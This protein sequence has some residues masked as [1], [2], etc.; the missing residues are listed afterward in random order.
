MFCITNDVNFNCILG[1]DSDDECDDD[2]FLYNLA[3]DAAAWLSYCRIAG[4]DARK[5]HYRQ[6]CRIRHFPFSRN[7]HMFMMEAMGENSKMCFQEFS[8]YPAMLR[9]F[10]HVLRDEHGLRINQHVN[11]YEQVGMFLCILAHGKGYRQV[12]TIF[13]HSLET[14]CHYV[15]EVLRAIVAL[16]TRLIRLSENYN[17]G[18]EPHRLDLS[19]HPLFEDCIGAI[20]GTHVKAM[21]PRY[22]RV[23]FIGRKGVPTQNVLAACDFNLFFT[24]VLAGYSGNTHDACMLARA[25]H[26]SKIHFPLPALGKYYL[27]DSGFAHRPRYMAPYKGSDILYHFQQFRD[28]R[29][30]SHRRFRNTREK[31]NFRHSSCRNVIERAFGVWKERWK[32]LDRMPRYPFRTQI[33]IVVATMGIH[34]FMRRSGVVDAAFTRAKVDEDAAEVE[35]P[36]VEDEIQAEIH[37]SKIQRSEWDRLQD[38]MAQQP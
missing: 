19:K 22:E 5:Y 10:V 20:D 32:I 27:V 3:I 8:M 26:D 13:N 38:Y 4:D 1:S 29:T 21:L 18:V 33:A 14:V 11:I 31:F 16:S 6:Q 30:G 36:N 25:I 23:N 35:L 7:G 37:A 2:Q 34:N 12:T 17:D 9:H 28:E 15:K 24:F